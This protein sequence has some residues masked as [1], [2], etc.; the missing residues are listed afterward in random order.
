MKGPQETEASARA[1]QIYAEMLGM[2]CHKEYIQYQQDQT[3][4]DPPLREHH[5][6]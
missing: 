4:H 2:I 3:V 6:N 5:T 1:A